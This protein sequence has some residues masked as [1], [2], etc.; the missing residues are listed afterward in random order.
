[1]ISSLASSKIHQGIGVENKHKVVIVVPWKTKIRH[2]LPLS[3]ESRI[4]KVESGRG[5]EGNRNPTLTT[6]AIVL[7]LLDV[8]HSIGM[9]R[10]IETPIEDD[11]EVLFGTIRIRGTSLSFTMLTLSRR[12]S[13]S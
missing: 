5:E 10:F 9:T 12:N 6:N 1:M 3:K 11:V 13:E 4:A 7:K 8:L 2:K